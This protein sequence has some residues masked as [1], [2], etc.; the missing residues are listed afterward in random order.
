M[1]F[2]VTFKIHQNSNFDWN[3]TKFPTQQDKMHMY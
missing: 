2:G 1:A 3:Q